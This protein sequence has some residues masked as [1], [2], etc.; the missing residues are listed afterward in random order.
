MSRCPRGDDLRATG[1]AAF[2]DP[3]FKYSVR[4]DLPPARPTRV[5]CRC[6]AS[7]RAE[8]FD[9]CAGAAGLALPQIGQP[10][11]QFPL[12]EIGAALETLGNFSVY[13]M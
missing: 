12:D 1:T 11:A 8:I 2:R 10:V 3:F 7:S 6:P 4:K 9:P 13:R 5:V